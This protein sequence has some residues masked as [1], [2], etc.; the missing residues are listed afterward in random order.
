[1]PT[2]AEWH[3]CVAPRSVH[4]RSIAPLVAQDGSHHDAVL[5]GYFGKDVNLCDGR[6]S[7]CRQP[8]AGSITH[9]HTAMPRG[10]ADFIPRE[11]LAAAEHGVFLESARGI[12]HYRIAARSNRHVDAPEFNPVYDLEADP[13][14]QHPIHAAEVEARLAAKLHELL[15]RY[16]APPCQFERLGL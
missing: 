9:H 16:D 7:Y 2:L 4:G 13:S 15:M 10:F 6:F 14:Q 12:A 1:M 5:Y 8:R 3:G 11:R